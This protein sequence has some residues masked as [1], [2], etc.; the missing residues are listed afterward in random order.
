MKYPV[1]SLLV[2]L[3]MEKQ[4]Y[5]YMRRPIPVYIDYFTAEVNDRGE[6]F[7]FIDVYGRDDKMKKALFTK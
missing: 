3:D 1:D 4:K 5:I 7:F 6:L 2:D